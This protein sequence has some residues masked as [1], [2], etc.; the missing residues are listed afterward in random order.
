MV[1]GNRDAKVNADSQFPGGRSGNIFDGDAR[2][3]S[4]HSS[5]SGLD[6]FR[7]HLYPADLTT[8]GI[9]LRDRDGRVGFCIISNVERE[10]E[11]QREATW[12]TLSLTQSVGDD[13][14]SSPYSRSSGRWNKR[15]RRHDP[16]PRS[17]CLSLP[18]NRARFAIPLHL[19]I[20]STIA[21]I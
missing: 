4:H 18:R 17:R 7:V 2:V 12:T 6:S 9:Q 14:L 21:L 11:R 19:S 1:F 13:H 3:Q 10:R 15:G 16:E 5:A 20:E 8:K